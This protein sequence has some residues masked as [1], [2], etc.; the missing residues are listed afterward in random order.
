MA[1]SVLPGLDV[2]DARKELGVLAR[3][4][5]RLRV[6]IARRVG[7]LELAQRLARLFASRD[8]PVLGCGCS[9]GK[10]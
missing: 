6:D 8:D 5:L 2:D 3:V 7:D 10:S 1:P 4:A 9:G